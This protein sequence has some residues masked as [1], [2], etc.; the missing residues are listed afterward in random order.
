M[1]ILCLFVHYCVQFSSILSG[2]QRI[3]KRLSNYE[4]FITG[5]LTG[6]VAS[7]AE[8]PIDLVSLSQLCE[9]V[10]ECCCLVYCY[11]FRQL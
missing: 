7:F 11:F 2:P 3:G 6:F 10:S 9:F 1:M 5:A 4:Y 8:S